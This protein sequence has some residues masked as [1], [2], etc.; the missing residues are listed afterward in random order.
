M[1]CQEVCLPQSPSR[2]FTFSRWE[3]GGQ[4]PSPHKLYQWCKALGLVLPPRTAL[5]RVCDISPELLRFLREDPAR[6]HALSPEKF[7]QFVAERLDRAGFLFA[8]GFE[9]LLDPHQAFM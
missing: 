5:V 2:R 1:S 4:S 8:P 9:P 3:A 7:E 6:L